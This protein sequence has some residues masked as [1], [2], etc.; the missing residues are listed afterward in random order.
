MANTFTKD[1]LRTGDIVV[2]R[3]RELGVVIAEKGVILFQ[4]S[5]MDYLDE[6]T[7][8]LLLDDTSLD[9]PVCDIMEVIRGWFG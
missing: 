5:G 9:Q 8:D 2:L 3:D 6:Y 1:D 7:E 4:N